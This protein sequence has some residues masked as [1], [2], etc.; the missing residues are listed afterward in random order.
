MDV[1]VLIICKPC[2]QKWGQCQINNQQQTPMKSQITS[3]NQS[4]NELNSSY[5]IKNMEHEELT[6]S[7]ITF[8]SPLVGL[9]HF[10]IVNLYPKHINHFHPPIRSQN[11][12]QRDNNNP[13]HQL[14]VC[15][16][17]DALPIP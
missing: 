7:S 1:F 5:E 17:N 16:N 15:T 4:Y 11:V 12:L 8:L 13:N 9:W 14:H 6:H 10:E 2:H 3:Y